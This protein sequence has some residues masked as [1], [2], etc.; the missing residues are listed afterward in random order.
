M[1]IAGQARRRRIGIEIVRS[2]LALDLKDGRLPHPDGLVVVNT[3]RGQRWLP[4]QPALFVNHNW[5]DGSI[6][7]RNASMIGI[8]P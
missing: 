5:L 4:G 8:V 2:I 6:P 3:A 7:W 1:P